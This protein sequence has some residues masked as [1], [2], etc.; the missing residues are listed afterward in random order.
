MNKCYYCNQKFDDKNHLRHNEHII[1]NAIGGRLKSNNIL[2]EKCGC[3]LGKKIDAPF[4]KIF[5]NICKIL[6]VTKD[7]GNDQKRIIRFSSTDSSTDN[8]F[9]YDCLTKSQKKQIIKY[10][11][12]KK[13][14]KT[15]RKKKYRQR[16]YF[17]S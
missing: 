7:H 3:D 1:Q 14:A 9:E 12:S 2:C 16:D 6:N 10:Y 11:L 8:I 4:V 5:E 13:I 15:T 17:L